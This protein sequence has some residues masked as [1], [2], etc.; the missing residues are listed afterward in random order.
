M[1]AA[2]LRALWR[3]LMG[4]TRPPATAKGSRRFLVRELAWA[5]E[6]RRWDGTPLGAMDSSTERLL[7]AAKRAVSSEPARARPRS[8]VPRS[9]TPLVRS[10]LPASSRLV[11][12]YRGV[13]HEVLVLDGGARFQYRGTTYRSLTAIAQEITGG[14][15]SGPK[16]FGLTTTA[17]LRSAST[18]RTGG[19]A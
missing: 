4:Q 19:A 9:S 11:R 16:F 2:A 1:S 6:S 15:R 7:A 17:G 13:E 10:P 14:T 5:I 3:E 12:R 18:R 8:C